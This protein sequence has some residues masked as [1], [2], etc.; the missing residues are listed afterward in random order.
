M[1]VGAITWTA[2][3][4]PDIILGRPI[5]VVE[6]QE[7]QVTVPVVVEPAGAGGPS[8]LVCHS[9]LGCNVRESSVAVIVIENGAA[10]PRDVEVRIAVVVVVADGHALAVMP[11]A[12]DPGFFRDV[13]KGSVTIVVVERRAEGP[14][15]LVNIGRS[16]LNEVEIHEPVLVVI[17][18]AHAGPHGLEIIL[19]LCLCGILEKGNSSSLADIGIPD[20]NSRRRRRLRRRFLC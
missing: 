10:V 2:L 14:R 8:A 9:C 17:N 20:T 16:R 18:P 5:D 4:T 19:F 12:A 3:S 15:R 7:V 1:A 6:D 11:L 13:G